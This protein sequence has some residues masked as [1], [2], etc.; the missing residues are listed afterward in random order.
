[1][2]FRIFS[3]CTD[4]DD[5]NQKVKTFYHRILARGY[6]PSAVRPIFQ[7]GY[8]QLRNRQNNVA[9]PESDLSTTVVFHLQYHPNNPPSNVIERA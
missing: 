3:L 8:N 4:P 2:I 1:M 5:A 9:V 6:K 7:K